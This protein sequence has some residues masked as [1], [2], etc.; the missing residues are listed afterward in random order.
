MKL[1][2]SPTNDVWAYEEDGSQDH[3]I[4]FDFVQITKEE[5]KI[6]VEQNK[7]QYFESLPYDVKR[8]IKYPTFVEQ[9]DMLYHE[10][11]DGWKAAIEAIKNQYPKP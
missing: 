7:T 1:F 9:L 10:G 5:A 11:Y 2:K 3:L 8:S 6:L 4:P